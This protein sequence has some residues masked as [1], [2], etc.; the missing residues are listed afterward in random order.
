MRRRLHAFGAGSNWNWWLWSASLLS[1][2]LVP[3]TWLWLVFRRVQNC[4]NIETASSFSSDPVRFVDYVTSHGAPRTLG[5]QLTSLGDLHR[6]LAFG[7]GVA[8][9]NLVV[10]TVLWAMWWKRAWLTTRSVATRRLVW[11]ALVGA[12]ADIVENI[13]QHAS[14]GLPGPAGKPRT[15]NIG[16]FATRVLPV[17]AWVKVLSFAAVWLL[18]LFTLIAAFSR[19][20]LHGQL[21]DGVERTAA[22]P[23]GLGIC[24]SGGGIRAASISLGALGVLERTG[25]DGTPLARCSGTDGILDRAKFLASVSGGGYTA[26][27]WRIARGTAPKAP[28]TDEFTALWPSGVIGSPEDYDDVP[29]DAFDDASTSTDKPSLFRHLQQRREF[30]KTGRGGFSGSLLTAVGLLAI[31]LV[32]LLGL[33]LVIAWPI[34]RLS[35]TSYVYGGIG[36]RVNAAIAANGDTVRAPDHTILDLSRHGD[37]PA[38]LCTKNVAITVGDELMRH[39]PTRARVFVSTPGRQFPITWRLYGP[40]AV[41]GGL[42]A[43]MFAF[44]LGQWNTTRRARVRAAA[45]GLAAAGMLTSGLLV[46]IPVLLDVVHPWLV[47]HATFGKLLAVVSGGGAVVSMVG[48]IRKMLG[49]RV[50]FLGGVLL[51]IGAGLLAIEI[52]AQ[53]AMGS[54][55]FV[56]GRILHGWGGWVLLCALL[57][58][59]YFLL[60]PRWWSLHTLYRNRLRGAFATTRKRA[61][62]P[63]RLRGPKHLDGPLWPI[64]QRDEPLLDEYVGAPGP[65]HLICCSAARQHRTNSGIKAL[66]FVM[67]P[68]EVVFYDV[69]PTSSGRMD[70]RRRLGQQVPVQ[71]YSA[72][73]STWVQALGSRRAV[74]AEGTVSAGMSVSGAAIAPAMGR[75]NKGST[76]AL[77]A[78]LNLRLGTWYPNPRYLAYPEDGPVRYP[79]VRL[80]YML[81]ELLG[82]YDLQDHHLYVT[83][84]GHRENLGLVELLRRRCNTIICID[85]SGD[86]PGSYATLRQAADLARVEV[87]ATIDLGPLRSW[88][89]TFSSESDTSGTLPTWQ[90]A[91]TT[92]SVRVGSPRMTAPGTE[93]PP[94]AHT[95]LDVTYRGP[96]GE[97]EGTGKIIHIAAVLYDCDGFPDDLVAFSLQDPQF[98]HYSTGDQFLNEKQF[99]CLVQFGEAATSH[100][101]ADPAVIGAVRASLETQPAAPAPSDQESPAVDSGMPKRTARRVSA[102]TR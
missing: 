48:M 4:P 96:N 72:P 99:R 8:L 50:V 73:T 6:N 61:Y 11:V 15:P 53:A 44:S 17:I 31:H 75:M 69:A 90:T 98:P 82:M 80:S 64:K 63:K 89:T 92:G 47:D 71:S 30:L 12:V 87:G 27:A 14:I 18:L 26:G 51:G 23:E 3:M 88:R 22:V 19:R 45:K 1:L 70:Q 58:V 29:P 101:L 5:C 100:A 95:V 76:M 41:F 42:A 59:G 66:S 20:R 56:L 28:T 9:A 85:S 25:G 67:S 86:S 65:I 60:C 54:N 93:R 37:L 46:V 10:F 38:S 97:V 39:S 40:A 79:W 77:L 36:C 33:L 81:K 21:S 16:W 24:C 84:G 52:S 49:P 102:S 2:F 32:L 83:D 62:A 34:G 57:C 78:A 74:R 68:E 55:V 7:Y 13:I 94:S 43:V 91:T 35:S